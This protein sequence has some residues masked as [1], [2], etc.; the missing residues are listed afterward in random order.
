MTKQRLLFVGLFLLTSLLVKAES[1]RYCSVKQSDYTKV[2]LTF[3][4]GNLVAHDLKTPEGM[5]SL[6]VIEGFYP[7]ADVGNP[8]LPVLSQTIEMPLCKGVS[9]R[10]ID[11]KTEVYNAEQL[12]V[13]YPVY[14]AQPLR[15]KSEEGP[16]PLV[17]NSETYSLNEFYGTDVIRIEE[18]GVAR[19]I[20]LA[21]VYFSPIKYNPVTN[22][23]SIVKELEVEI[24]FEDAD[25]AATRKMKKLHSSSAFSVK[26][27]IANVLEKDAYT[28]GPLKYLIVSHSSFKGQFDEFVAWKKRKGFL[29]DI[30]Y[31]DDANVGTTTTSI[32]AYLK[33]Q[34]TNATAEN[35]APTYVLL[36]GDIQQIPPFDSRVSSSYMN[37]HITD[38]YYFTW[39]DGDIIPDCYYG[40]FSAQTVAHLTPQIEKTLMYEQYLME[41]PSYLDKALVVAGEDGGQRGD[42]GYTHA[43][44]VI[45]Y[46]EDNYVNANYG[47]TSVTS[48]YNP[49]SGTSA[50]ETGVFN[51]LSNGVGYAN[52]SAHCNYDNWSIPEFNTSDVNRMQNTQKFGLMIGNCCLSNK[53]DVSS[54]LGEALLRKGNYCGAV[55]YIG[56]SNSTYWD[57]DYWWAVGVRTINTSTCPTPAYS[58]ANLGAYDRLFHTHNESYADWY[59][60]NGAIIMAGNMAVQAAP[61]STTY[62][63]YYWEIYHL[64]GDPSVMSYLTQ[65]EVMDVNVSTTLFNDAQSLSVQAV[66]YAYVALTDNDGELV[67]ATFAD[68][69]GDATLSFEPLNTVGTFELAVSAQNYQI[70]FTEINVIA[71]TGPFVIVENAW[72]NSDNTANVGDDARIAIEISNVGVEDAQNVWLEIKSADNRKVVVYDTMINVGSMQVGA[73]DTLYTSAHI[74]SN[75]PNGERLAINVT[76]HFADNKTSIYTCRFVAEGYAIAKVDEDINNITTSQRSYLL[77]GDTLL[78]SIKYKNIGTL[79]F[80]YLQNQVYSSNP[81]VSVSNPRPNINLLPAD[82]QIEVEYTIALNQA[83][84]QNVTL[85]I[86]N[87]MSNELYTYRDTVMLSLKGLVEDFETGNFTKY[88][89]NNT[90]QNPWEIATDDKVDGQYSMKSKTNL[91]HRSTSKI[92]ITWTS[93]IDDSISYYRKVSTES[94]YDKF[95][96]KMDGEE[97]ENASGEIGWERAAFFVPAGTHTFSFEYDKDY[98]VSEGSNCVWIDY[99][100]LPLNSSDTYTYIIDT[101]CQGA[102]FESGNISVN[103]ADLDPATYYYADSTSS[104]TTTFAMLTVV[105]VPDVQITGTSEI[106]LG[107]STKLTASGASQYMW[108]NG[109]TLPVMN[110]MPTATTQYTV[111]GY[112]KGC[113]SDTA[114]ITIKVNGV[115]I[116]QCQTD[117]NISLYP[118]PTDKYVVVESDV[119]IKNIAIFDMVGRMVDMIDTQGNKYHK[120]NLE[121]YKGGSYLMLLN[122][123]DGQTKRMH[124]L[125]VK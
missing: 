107:E 41:D 43:D 101:V 58:A 46:L 117:A 8:N 67:A 57:Q 24:V 96:F 102:I 92:S 55:G 52:Y 72:A 78:L 19:N 37:D 122:L 123:V 71:P 30:V 64:M 20:N 62:K 120:C 97:M 60:S 103:T 23:I 5:Y 6:L 90:D 121:N 112:A 61:T 98:S 16:F 109:E 75:V 42:H 48:Y 25:V 73:I 7:S 95:Y 125:V 87:T 21:N 1:V 113:Q 81:L 17:K 36:V 79:P 13:K 91:D 59:T 115:G 4:A 99:L 86:Y 26:A 9:Y 116:T 94:N 111:V 53:F 93:T 31:T 10:V 14:P 82:G 83:L 22:E 114:S 70:S 12:G 76:V 3:K 56:G 39:T 119:E 106:Q 35:P 38:L 29:V 44:P 104:N 69:N 27:D 65:A 66:P 34:Y 32:Q 15:S 54:C 50:A 28:T 40:R 110:V 108:S 68:V 105:A 84:K 74:F 118:N 77:P 18:V 124:L 33:S 80:R 11:A 47:Y 2:S 49:S 100:Q 88:T 85:P 45:H 89:W 63:T 51:A